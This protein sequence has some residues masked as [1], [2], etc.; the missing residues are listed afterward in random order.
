MKPHSVVANV[1]SLGLITRFG[2]PTAWLSETLAGY[3]VC[4]ARAAISDSSVS[5][6][7]KEILFSVAAA[8]SYLIEW[9]RDEVF[10][11][12]VQ[13]SAV[14]FGARQRKQG[15]CE[16]WKDFLKELVASNQV[17]AS[18]NFGTSNAW[19]AFG[20]IVATRNALVHGNYSRP[21]KTVK[22][23]ERP[24]PLSPE[25]LLN[26]PPGW[27]VAAVVR[28]VKELCDSTRTRAP[29]WL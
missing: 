2:T 1:A 8:E 19:L 5:G 7:R 16:R 4:E 28:I 6:R 25:E 27:A 21:R 17:P 14:F 29:A 10:R 11:G 22:L 23:N 24:E 13:A 12:N 9:V 18:P 20:T 15:I 26:K 3:W